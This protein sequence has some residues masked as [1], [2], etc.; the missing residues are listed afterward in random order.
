MLDGEVVSPAE[1]CGC[2]LPF[3]LPYFTTK[4]AHANKRFPRLSISHMSSLVTAGDL[5][6]G[7]CL[8]VG[9]RSVC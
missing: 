1:T 4:K 6:R 2:C 9:I 7:L 5:N 3:A 8:H